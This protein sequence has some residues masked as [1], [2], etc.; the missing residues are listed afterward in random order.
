MLQN[1]QRALDDPKKENK[2]IPELQ[3]TAIR[4]FVMKCLAV[5]YGTPDA[6]TFYDLGDINNKKRKIILGFLLDT[7][8]NF[9]NTFAENPY[10]RARR[11]NSQTNEPQLEAI[12][13]TALWSSDA[14][15]NPYLRI[16]AETVNQGDKVK[17]YVE[18][19]SPFSESYRFFWRI[20][21]INTDVVPFGTKSSYEIDTNE[22]AVGQQRI[23]FQVTPHKGDAPINVNISFTI[24]EGIEQTADN[25]QESVNIPEPITISP[26]EVEAKIVSSGLKAAYDTAR[27]SKQWVEMKR[28]E[29]VMVEFRQTNI[30][31]GF[32]NIQA[33]V[34]SDSLTNEEVLNQNNEVTEQ[35][36][37]NDF[38][39]AEQIIDAETGNPMRN[40]SYKIIFK[41]NGKVYEN[42]TDEAGYIYLDKNIPNSEYEIILNNYS[43]LFVK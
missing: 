12:I 35:E 8:S 1:A 25:E 4:S 15:L 5:K 19:G 34:T 27:I 40:I 22:L 36:V 3:E 43:T 30:W 13:P 39:I 21:G 18:N 23:Q 37:N 17:A 9:F 42:F 24:A 10:E 6:T 33:G 14:S 28:L 7:N 20:A 41:E 31:K 2:R 38:Y 29:A 26:R 11:E 16:S 32:Q